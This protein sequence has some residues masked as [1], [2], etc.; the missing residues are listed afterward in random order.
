MCEKSF[1]SQQTQWVNKLSE[2]KELTNPA[3]L[4]EM[5]F[6]PSAQV[7]RVISDRETIGSGK[8]DHILALSLTS[9][10]P[11]HSGAPGKAGLSHRTLAPVSCVVNAFSL[12]VLHH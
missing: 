7:T 1:S 3:P 10:V 8:T 6:L 12:C 9:C 5:A 2:D 11:A 4:T